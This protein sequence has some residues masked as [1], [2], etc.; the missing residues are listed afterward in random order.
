MKDKM[1][2]YDKIDIAW[3]QCS[4]YG[5]LRDS[6]TCLYGMDVMVSFG[7]AQLALWHGCYGIL[8]DSPACLYG[9][10]VMV[11]FRITQLAFMAWMLWYPL[12]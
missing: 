9:M 8:R 11:S 12:G 4:S 7:I 1:S 3:I 5:I 2:K 6:P 10:D